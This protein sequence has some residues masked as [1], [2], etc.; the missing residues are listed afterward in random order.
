MTHLEPYNERSRE[1][2]QLAAFPRLLDL[3]CDDAGVEHHSVRRPQDNLLVMN[4]DVPLLVLDASARADDNTISQRLKP[5]VVQ[6]LQEMVPFIE[7]D[8]VERQRLVRQINERN[9]AVIEDVWRRIVE[10]MQKEYPQKKRELALRLVPEPT[11]SPVP[12]PDGNGNPTRGLYPRFGYASPELHTALAATGNLRLAFTVDTSVIFGRDDRRAVEE[13]NRFYDASRW[14]MNTEDALLQD[15][16]LAQAQVVSEMFRCRGLPQF[17]Q[18]TVEDVRRRFPDAQGQ[19][20]LQQL[21][22]EERIRYLPRAEH[23]F[24]TIIEVQNYAHVIL[25]L[26]GQ[27]GINLSALQELRDLGIDLQYDVNRRQFTRLSL[28]SAVPSSLEELGSA[29]SSSLEGNESNNAKWE[30]LQAW[31]E[32]HRKA[33]ETVLRPIHEAA[34]RALSRGEAPQ[35]AF[36][37][38][39]HENVPGQIRVGDRLERYDFIDHDFTL[40]DRPDGQVDIRRTR[41]YYRHRTVGVGGVEVRAGLYNHNRIRVGEPEKEEITVGR[42][43]LVACINHFGNIEIVRAGGATEQG[44]GLAAWRRD[45]ILQFGL[46]RYGAIALD[47]GMV[48]TGTLGLRAALTAGRL[49]AAAVSGARVA[50]GAGGMV[51]LSPGLQRL[52]EAAMLLDVT[53]QMFFARYRQ[54]GGLPKLGSNP[55]WLRRAEHAADVFGHGA[56]YGG[57]IATSFTVI[58]ATF[59]NLTGRENNRAAVALAEHLGRPAPAG[60]PSLF[61]FSNERVRTGAQNVLRDYFSHLFPGGTLPA[62]IQEIQRNVERLI[63]APEGDR[64]AYCRQLMAHFRMNGEQIARLH[65]RLERETFTDA[66]LRSIDFAAKTRTNEEHVPSE[67]QVAAAVAL[68]MLS[69]RKDGTLPDVLAERQERVSAWQF[70]RETSDQR[71]RAT[72]VVRGGGDNELITQQLRTQDLLPFIRR[73]VIADRPITGQR[74]VT[75]EALWH[76]G[77][78]SDAGLAG[79]YRDAVASGNQ[80]L[81]MRALTG[82][83]N[84]INFGQLIYEMQRQESQMSSC[85]QQQQELFMLRRH[86]LTSRDLL[87]FLQTQIRPAGEGDAD[88]QAAIIGTRRVL[89]PSV[90]NGSSAA[91]I[92]AMAGLWQQHGNNPGA[93]ARH[94]FAFIAQDINRPT[95][96]IPSMPAGPF[97]Q[98]PA[99]LASTLALTQLGPQD[100]MRRQARDASI[101]LDAGRID[102]QQYND[103]LI[104]A[105]DE[106]NPAQ[107]LVMLAGLRWNSL[108]VQQRERVLNLLVHNPT[109]DQNE[110]LKLAILGRIPQ[111]FQVSPELRQQ[112]Q[113]NPE[114]AIAPLRAR[115]I[116][117]LRGLITA[118]TND[119]LSPNF[120][121]DYEDVRVAAVN[122]I[123]FF[124]QATDRATIEA[125]RGRLRFVTGGDGSGVF[126]EVSP[127]VRLAVVEALNRLRPPD[128]RNILEDDLVATGRGHESDPAVRA[129]AVQILRE[130]GMM[131]RPNEK[132]TNTLFQGLLATILRGQNYSWDYPLD[133]RKR[134]IM[135][136]DKTLRPSTSSDARA[137]TM[138]EWLS[139]KWPMLIESSR[140][141]ER[142]NTGWFEGWRWGW[143]SDW[144]EYD[145]RL[146]ATFN[147]NQPNSLWAQAMQGDMNAIRALCYIIDSR[148]ETII[149]DTAVQNKLVGLS[150][151]ILLHLAGQSHENKMAV[152]GLILNLIKKENL[153]PSAEQTLFL[154]VWRMNQP[155][156]QGHTALSNVEAAEAYLTLLGKRVWCEAPLTSQHPGYKEIIQVQSRCLSELRRLQCRDERVISLLQ[157]LG[158]PLVRRTNDEARNTAEGR[159]VDPQINDAAR[160]TLEYLMEGVSSWLHHTHIGRRPDRDTSTQRRAEVIEQA[161]RAPSSQYDNVVEAIFTAIN[162][163]DDGDARF[164]RPDDPLVRTLSRIM[165]GHPPSQRLQLAAS[166]ALLKLRIG[167]EVPRNGGIELRNL[168]ALQQQSE[169]IRYAAVR[170]LAHLAGNAQLPSHRREARDFLTH[171][172]T[173]LDRERLEPQSQLQA[174]STAYQGIKFLYSSILE[175]TYYNPPGSFDPVRETRNIA[176]ARQRLSTDNRDPV[177]VICRACLAK[178]FV[179][180]DPRLVQLA[181]GMQHENPRISAI[182]CILLTYAD[183]QTYG[184]EAIQRLAMLWAHNDNST[185]RSDMVQFIAMA[186]P[187]LRRVLNEL[188]A[189]Q[190][191]LEDAAG[192]FRI[193]I[194]PNRYL[195]VTTPQGRAPEA[196][197]VEGQPAP[198]R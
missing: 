88:L 41:T 150:A 89:D 133:D 137:M 139:Q 25:A 169:D 37:Q 58:P 3:L 6:A 182:C 61:D 173:Q 96:V 117:Y 70:E 16:R 156:Q 2:P 121:C 51:E 191:I 147:T 53:G 194:G 83:P 75:A 155:D 146:E 49:G 14:F 94:F 55:G 99:E 196:R 68:L 138:R 7:D 114:A 136:D 118:P 28:G 195:K 93:F 176:N 72:E 63:N 190:Q 90:C 184:H 128:L 105:F 172:R 161:L 197:V 100:T 177:E 31:I 82:A 91:L 152:R 188:P 145:R 11:H 124:G 183:A 67:T 110:I 95:I 34:A 87:Q 104:S 8:S 120:A 24:R 4:Q 35:A 86:N 50:I 60:L 23:C 5:Y 12:L 171:N 162:G 134:L 127:R 108:T 135:V 9:L 113:G 66:D 80:A 111:L 1:Q 21:L 76:F 178:P 132:R 17:Q 77:A 22:I 126:V 10:W 48:V 46:S 43:Q 144:A 57:L 64:R 186:V 79:I 164:T 125:L 163:L 42:N 92:Q 74:L 148:A 185:L 153:H 81:A 179:P 103:R 106:G 33:I 44:H 56:M 192:G 54:L 123:A 167:V 30:A 154:A 122:A 157:A 142:D 149:S 97:G 29:V 62:D 71:G 13:L 158:H 109:N 141:K 26:H 84:S 102:V 160:E 187:S 140:N 98:G 101:L 39:G 47:L 45:E 112:L 131:T 180:N 181:A 36:V 119:Q 189:N 130:I 151:A 174:A 166:M 175:Q 165:A 52:R 170:T 69:V 59:D 40:H 198:A 73:Y 27:Q 65:E 85:T 129:R 32:R 168:A 159:N 78:V 193:R 143:A 20:Q 38:W 115:A 15:R 107:T 18:P 116:A 19:E